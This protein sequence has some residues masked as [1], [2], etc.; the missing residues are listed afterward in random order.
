MKYEEMKVGDYPSIFDLGHIGVVVR[1]LGH[2][3]D[4]LSRAFGVGPWQLAEHESESGTLKTG[5]SLKLRLAFA[6]L[7]NGLRIE[8]IQPFEGTSIWSDYLDRRGEGLHHICL[9]V[10]STEWDA[11]VSTLKAKECKLI[12]S[13]VFQGKRSN[14]YE[15][16]VGNVLIQIEEML[17]R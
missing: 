17:A 12:S 7:G 8:L 16:N 3:T 13:T 6:D 14:Y 5:K 11:T 9:H 4:L 15:P 2:A 10:P 1:D